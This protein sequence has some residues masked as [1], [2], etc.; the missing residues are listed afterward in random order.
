MGR[1]GRN[2]ENTLAPE[3]ARHAQEMLEAYQVNQNERNYKA[4][5][6]RDSKIQNRRPQNEEFQKGSKVTWLNN[7]NNPEKGEVT[8]VEVRGGVPMAAW[9][10]TGGQIKKV[11]YNALKQLAARRPQFLMEL[12]VRLEEGMLAFWQDEEEELVG[13]MVM[14]ADDEETMLVHFYE[15]NKNLRKWLPLWQNEEESKRAEE[16]PGGMEAS[17]EMVPKSMARRSGFVKESGFVTEDTLLMLQAWLQ[18]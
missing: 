14:D 9:V 12:D 15:G 3:M 6:D 13:A 8:A 4:A 7:N 2:L 18:E 5:F 11:Q 17:V 16:C 1:P 10:N